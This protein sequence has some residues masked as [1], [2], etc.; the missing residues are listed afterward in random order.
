[1]SYDSS[2][3]QFLSTEEIARLDTVPGRYGVLYI[4]KDPPHTEFRWN[5]T[6][7]LPTRVGGIHEFNDLPP[8]SEFPPG[9]P[10]STSDLGEVAVSADGE[11]WERPYSPPPV[12]IEARLEQVSRDL[13]QAMSQT[14]VAPTD[15]NLIAALA[16]KAPVKNA[17]MEGLQ[18][19]T[20]PQSAAGNEAV[21]AVWVRQFVA[22]AIE[23]ALNTAPPVANA[24][25]NTVTPT[26]TTANGAVAQPGVQLLGS[27]G[28]WTGTATITFAYQW[29]RG[30]DPISGATVINYTAT[31]DDVGPLIRLRV[32]ASNGVLSDVEAWSAGLFITGLAAPT[33][34]TPPVITVDTSTPTDGFL[35]VWKHTKRLSSYALP[36]TA[37]AG[38]TLIAVQVSDNDATTFTWPAGFTQIVSQP[39]TVDGMRIGVA[40]KPAASG[41]EGTLL[42][43]A[44]TDT[45]RGCIAILNRDQ[46]T[47]LDVAAVVS[48]D[49]VAAA[50]PWS[51]DAVID[52]VTAGCQLL[53]IAGSDVNIDQQVTHE[54]SGGGLVWTKRE[55]LYDNANGF[56]NLTIA[57]A[58]QA[59]GHAATTLTVVG[60]AGGG[61]Q[62]GQT[63]VLLALRK[64]AGTGSGTE[65][66]NILTA[67]DAVW[68]ATPT[69]R[70]KQWYRV[71]NGALVIIPGADQAAKA[72]APS[73][74]GQSL[75]V[76]ETAVINGQSY[77]S[78]SAAVNIPL[79]PNDYDFQP[80]VG[81]L[82]PGSTLDAQEWESM[83]SGGY[84]AFGD[85]VNWIIGE[86]DGPISCSS[87][88]SG[89]KSD[90]AVGRV[91]ACYLMPSN[92]LDVN[93]PPPPPPPPVGG[94]LVFADP[95]VVVMLDADVAVGSVDDD[96][97]TQLA[98][99]APQNN[100]LLRNCTP[101]GVLHSDGTPWLLRGVAPGG[102]QGWLHR[103]R[104]GQ[105]LFQ[106]STLRAEM[107]SGYQSQQEDGGVRDGLD[108]WLALDWYFESD[109]FA[110]GATDGISLFDLHGQPGYGGFPAS[111]YHGMAFR[112]NSGGRFSFH[113]FSEQGTVPGKTYDV[114]DGFNT[115]VIS[116]VPSQPG[117]PHGTPEE[118]ILDRASQAGQWY[119]AIVRMKLGSIASQGPRTQLWLQKGNGALTKLIDLSTPNNGLATG[120]WRFPKTGIYKFDGVFGSRGTRS[121]WRR[122]YVIARNVAGS[123]TLDENVMHN[124][125][126]R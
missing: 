75:V 26:V 46:T 36:I 33:A 66:G 69:G 94:S 2:Y 92:P 51:Q 126:L 42:L 37:P 8:P 7:L 79:V 21:P 68:T 83:S 65:V 77:T 67:E 61:A 19:I 88:A 89:F 70:S 11:R 31:A 113:Q 114:T 93:P 58:L 56:F 62:A 100:F 104:N 18:L 48:N 54:F 57:T 52:P 63:V 73:D 86:P 111:G 122:G 40:I 41:T 45:I 112:L 27:N 14:V 60:S 106:G 12:D 1:M 80:Y 6:R 39:N 85:G 4:A 96:L 97:V 25:Q 20:P 47:T 82:P 78:T 81:A 118:W 13:Y 84:A 5:G 117:G 35:Q 124:W 44:S 71:V 90:P 59:V 103:L 115:T 110:S 30:A 76:V 102:K 98:D 105:P 120:S 72:I 109:M 34:S 3:F 108:Y 50:S 64:A 24:P 43:E 16:Q 74:L 38:A 91:K 125:L 95:R 15:P 29:F 87:L 116:T 99:A 28:T 107:F 101:N 22:A 53:A 9:T 10:A 32:R 49:N 23:S 55:D 17:V 119:R 123:P 121:F